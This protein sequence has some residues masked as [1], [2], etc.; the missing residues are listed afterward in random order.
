MTRAVTLEDGTRIE[1]LEVGEG[2]A[3]VYF[4]GAGGVFPKARFAAELGTTFRVLSPSRPGYDGSSGV[5][6]SAREEAEVMGAFMRQVCG[7]P[8]HVVAES[9]GGAAGCWLAV[10]YPDLVKTLILVAPTAFITRHEPPPAPAQMETVLFGS[11]PAWTEPLTAED[12]TRRQRNAQAN[13]GR[14]RSADG[15]RALLARLPEIQTP[16]LILWGSADQL[17]PPDAGQIYK[18]HIAN[19]HRLYV[20][21]AAHSLPVAACASFVRLTREFIDRGEAFIVNNAQW[22]SRQ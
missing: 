16:T 11:Q 15:N 14:A 20:Y 22:G 7:G 12:V 19:S 13:A 8:A 10:L 2:E 21:D 1:Y 6:D 4:H 18:Q 3:L 9:A 5:C 17:A